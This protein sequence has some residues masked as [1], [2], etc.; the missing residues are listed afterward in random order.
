MSQPGFVANFVGTSRATK[1]ATKQDTK[2]GSQET[3][4]DRRP[5]PLNLTP[6]PHQMGAGRG[7]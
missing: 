1:Y 7:G 3:T 5:L 6:A 2:E 4:I